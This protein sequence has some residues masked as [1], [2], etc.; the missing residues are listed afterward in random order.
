[1]EE[2]TDRGFGSDETGTDQN[3][4]TRRRL[5]DEETTV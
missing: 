2:T 1:M 5:E 4:Q 3:Q